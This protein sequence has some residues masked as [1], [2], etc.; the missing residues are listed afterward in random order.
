MGGHTNGKESE[1]GV[2]GRSSRLGAH[3]SVHHF[4]GKQTPTASI[5]LNK[6]PLLVKQ[7]ARSSSFSATKSANAKHAR[8]MSLEARREPGQGVNTALQRETAKSRIRER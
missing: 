1:L 4:V 2:Q 6:N 3:V 8:R 7:L 5:F